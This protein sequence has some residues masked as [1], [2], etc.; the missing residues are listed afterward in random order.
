MIHESDWRKIGN[1]IED[2]ILP[3]HFF[4]RPGMDLVCQISRE[5]VRWELFRGRLVPPEHARETKNFQAWN[6]YH[7]QDRRRSAEPILSIKVDVEASQVH[8]VRA[9]LSYAWEGYDAGNSVIESRETTRWLPE[10]V[11]TIEL[12]EFRDDDDLRAEISHLVS[13]AF[14]GTS[15]L[16][17]TSVESPLPG[18]SLGHFAF[19]DLK[20]AVSSPIRRSCRDLMQGCFWARL[21]V[22][23]FSR[24]LEVMFRA[25]AGEEIPELACLFA[26]RWTRLGNVPRSLLKLLRT[27]FNATSLSPW[28]GLADNALRFL[29][30]LVDQEI[31]FPQDQADFLAGLLCQLGRHLTAYDLVTFHHRGANYPDALLLDACLKSYLELIERY[32]ELFKNAAGRKRRRAL[33]QAWFFRTHY[34]GLYVPDAPT[35]PGENTRVLPG[36]HVR[37]PEEQLLHPGKR[38]RR[39]YD[40]NPLNLPEKARVVLQ[41]SL[42]DLDECEELLELGL[43]V[44]IDR[45]LAAGK[46][47]G[48]PDRTPLLSYL[49]FSRCI[50]SRRL[51]EIADRTRQAGLELDFLSLSGAVQELPVRGMSIEKVAAK[52]MAVVS[53]ADV[54]KS[55]EDFALLETLRTGLRQF[56]GLFDWK[57]LARHVNLDFLQGPGKVLIAPIANTAEGSPVLAVFDGELTRRFELIVDLS[58]GYRLRRG[59]EAPRAGL[60]ARCGD[61]A[62]PVPAIVDQTRIC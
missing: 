53:L 25:A 18:F 29:Q 50:A 16:P 14:I 38:Q 47:P 27:L 15:R 33:R 42:R 58:Q 55:A 22:P 19:F 2:V 34:E 41:E 62:I 6:L 49:A 45:P 30:A 56:L 17:L 28:T 7:V 61:V 43:G 32:P 3:G 51:Q 46:A 13:D 36:P 54:C 11:G 57:P 20:D 10:L 5:Q 26:E 52:R 23:E 48:E 31:L 1:I 37:V 35:S 4:V 60:V 12:A 59:V 40:G 21:G 24:L 8:V 39:L 44:F 9:I